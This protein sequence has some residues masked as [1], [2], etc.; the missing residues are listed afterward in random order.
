MSK[1]V[2]R[3]IIIVLS[4]LLIIISLTAD[5]IGIGSYP[6]IHYAQIIGASVGLVALIIGLWLLLKSDKVEK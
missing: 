6:G 3:I 5:F 2:L 4:S 1:K